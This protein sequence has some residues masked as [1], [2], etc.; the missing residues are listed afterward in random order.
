MGYLGLTQGDFALEE[1][2]RAK[3]TPSEDW[4]DPVSYIRCRRRVARSKW[5]QFDYNEDMSPIWLKVK[6]RSRMQA[7]ARFGPYLAEAKGHAAFA[8][9]LCL[10]N[11]CLAKAFVFPLDTV[12]VSVRNAVEGV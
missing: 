9:E 3:K 1:C 8:L 11:S 12:E 5:D 10:Y 2:R 6:Y 4:P 7:E